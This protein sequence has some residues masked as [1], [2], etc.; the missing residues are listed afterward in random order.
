MIRVIIERIVAEG[1]E[2]PYEEAAR[3][4]LA[5]ALA[6]PGF[7]SGESLRDLRRPGR[8][9]V[10]CTWR[11]VNDWEQWFRS[12]VRRECLA[13]I[14]PMLETGENITILQPD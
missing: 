4:T 14:Q 5:H 2:A 8:R 13:Q 7:I 11:N 1:L 12:D 10:L 9:V 6:Q 3:R